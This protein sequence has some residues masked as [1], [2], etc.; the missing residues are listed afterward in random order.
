[1]KFTAILDANI[2]LYIYPS[3]LHPNSNI[4]LRLEKERPEDG[5]T[6]P[7]YLALGSIFVLDWTALQCYLAR[8]RGGAFR[9]RF[10]KDSFNQSTAS[11][12]FWPCRWVETGRL[13]ETFIDYKVPGGDEMLR[14]CNK[15]E[16]K[17]YRYKIRESL[18]KCQD[19]WGA[20]I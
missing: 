10:T 12:V 20:F 7:S 13:W 8:Q 15:G 17:R 6:S 11:I 19:L 16:Q 1:M 4:L 3:A 9:Y 5:I 2:Y 14:E 18:K